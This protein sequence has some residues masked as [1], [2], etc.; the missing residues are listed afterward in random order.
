MPIKR[1]TLK[2]AQQPWG[3]VGCPAGH[4]WGTPDPDGSDRYLDCIDCDHRLDVRTLPAGA[5][6]RILAELPKGAPLL[7]SV[8]RRVRAALPAD[9]RGRVMGRD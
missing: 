4:D 8:G 3:R 2:E 1:V 7:G 9:A 5:A 6:D